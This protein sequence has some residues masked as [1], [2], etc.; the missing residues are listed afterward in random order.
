MQIAP[1]KMPGWMTHKLESRLLGEM[2]TIRYAE[3]NTLI[4]ENEEEI[5]RLLMKVR[6]AKELV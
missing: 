5:K 3:G 2:P 4:E 6:G 1:C